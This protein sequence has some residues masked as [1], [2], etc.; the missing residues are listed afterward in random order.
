MFLGQVVAGDVTIQPIERS[1]GKLQFSIDPRMELLAAIHL[2]S[3]NNDLVNR[4]LSYSREVCNYFDSFS[5]EEAVPLTGNLKL[6]YGFSYDAPVT[7]MLHLSQLPKLEKQIEYSDYLLKRSGGVDNLEQY[8]KAIRQFAG[9][10]NF[11]DF[12]NSKISFYH[13]I[14][15]ATI[16]DIGGNDLVKAMEDYFNE[17]QG[18]YH[19]VIT[20]AFYGGKGPKI[21]GTDGKDQIYACVSPTDMQNGIPYLNENNLCHYVWH[22]FGHSFVNPLTSRYIDRVLSQSKLFEPIKDVMSGQAYRSWETCVNEHI[23]RAVH[24]RLI[25]LNVDSLQSKALLSN[26]LGNGFIYIEPLLEKLKDFESQRDRNRVTFTEFYPELLNVLDSLQQTEYR[27][28]VNMGFRGPVNGVFINAGGWE[29]KI[30]VIYPTEDPDKEALKIVQEYVSLVFERFFKQKGGV[31]LADTTALETDLSDYGIAV[32]GSIESNL[33]LKRYASSFPFRIENQTIY[34]DKEYKDENIKLI[35]CIPNPLN[36][37]KGMAVY[38][39]LSNRAMRDINNVNHGNEDYILFMNRET[40]I[41]RGFY[42]KTG[43]WSF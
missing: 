15:D 16:G 40:V 4:N 42:T 34:A 6:Q 32:Y 2:L 7:L 5:S 25:D 27:E 12:W 36:P 20:P 43:K 41:N 10:S 23:I 21:P 33:F 19:I 14:V 39:A 18:S 38:T 31:L 9:T 11:E 35:T 17:T 26:E 13:Q 29:K 8:R 24:I 1:V 3:G 22:E 37:K 28:L 30:A